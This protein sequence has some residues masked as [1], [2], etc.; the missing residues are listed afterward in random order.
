ME[1]KLKN[2]KIEKL[3]FGI[4]HF[5]HTRIEKNT[6]KL[7]RKP[8]LEVGELLVKDCLMFGNTKSFPYICIEIE[9]KKF[10]L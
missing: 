1:K 6:S 3:F 2:Q 7:R 4:F 8:R 9:E 10:S 5:R